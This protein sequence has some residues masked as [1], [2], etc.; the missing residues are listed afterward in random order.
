M[1]IS[2]W[3]SRLSQAQGFSLFLSPLSLVEML[4]KVM[5]WMPC[6][7]MGDAKRWNAQNNHFRKRNE[8]S[9]ATFWDYQAVLHDHLRFVVMNLNENYLQ[10]LCV[11]VYINDV[12]H[13]PCVI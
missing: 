5:S 11:C 1:E 3:A 4:S 2:K 13:S 8:L 6:R 12:C 9:R 7:D 10:K